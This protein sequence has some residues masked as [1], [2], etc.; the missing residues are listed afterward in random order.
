M[1][2][3][4]QIPSV[5]LDTKPLLA[6]INGLVNKVGFIDYFKN[7]DY[8]ILIENLKV[9]SAILTVIFAGIII[10]VIYRMRDLVRDELAELKSEINPPAE[11]QTA[12][13]ARWQEI[14][15]HVNSFKDSD[16]KLAV[17][18][19]DKFVD[20]VLKIAGFQGDSMGERLMTIT[21]DQILN[22]QNLWDAHK[23][24]NL[25]AHDVSYQVTHRQAVLA[26]E[27]FELVLRELGALS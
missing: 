23:L 25:I 13:D 10:M 18:E 5:V 12:N 7:L 6:Q 3:P 8:R 11:A 17:I 14:K 22:I 19:A 2:L 16:W 4:I 15:D 24:R 9:V 26:V 21:Q 27:S 20:N 1:S